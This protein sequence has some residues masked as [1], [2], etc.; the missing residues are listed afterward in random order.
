MKTGYFVRMEFLRTLSLIGIHAFTAQL[1]RHNP[2]VK[3]LMGRWSAQLQHAKQCLSAA[4]DRQKAY[5][6]KRR[7]PVKSVNRETKFSSLLSVSSFSLA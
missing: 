1:R 3:Q 5:A 6:D 7:R 2:D 4:Q